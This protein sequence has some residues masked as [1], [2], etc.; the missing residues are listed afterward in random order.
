MACFIDHILLL[1]ERPFKY[2]KK[3]SWELVKYD[4][5]ISL[6]LSWDPKGLRITGCT[7]SP[8]LSRILSRM[9]SSNLGLCSQELCQCKGE[10]E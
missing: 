6:K 8:M 3:S 2:K 4:L 10:E 1:Y 7:T 9:L 5:E